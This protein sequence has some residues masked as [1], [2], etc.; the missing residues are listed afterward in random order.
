M[1]SAWW[2]AAPAM[3]LR[4]ALRIFR[5]SVFLITT[6]EADGIVASSFARAAAFASAFAFAI[7]AAF[8]AALASASSLSSSVAG[9]PLIAFS[10][11]PRAFPASNSTTGGPGGG[12]H[13]DDDAAPDDTTPNAGGASAGNVFSAWLRIASIANGGFGPPLG[14]EPAAAASSAAAGAGTSSLTILGASLPSSGEASAPAACCMRI[15]S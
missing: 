14:A 1:C 4:R 13:D 5:P 7:A 11:P 2:C 8:A 6:V 9:A 12:V 10:T 15:V 3:L